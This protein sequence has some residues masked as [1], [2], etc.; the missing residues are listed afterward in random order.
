MGTGW[1]NEE[2]ADSKQPVGKYMYQQRKIPVLKGAKIVN[3]TGAKV[4]LYT[5]NGNTRTFE[6]NVTF[7]P[8]GPV[9]L[10]VA[11]EIVIRD[12]QVAIPSADLPG[13]TAESV[14]GESDNAGLEE[15]VNSG[16]IGRTDDVFQEASMSASQRVRDA[17]LEAARSS[18]PKHAYIQ[19]I[20]V[21]PLNLK[22]LPDPVPNT[23]YLLSESIFY[24]AIFTGRFDVGTP[25]SPI[26]SGNGTVIGWKNIREG[27]EF[28]PRQPAD[29]GKEVP[30]S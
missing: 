18:G 3:L 5:Y 29:S 2:P 24:A 21:L 30:S 16:D 8:D 1:S 25:Y 13:E 10:V 4:S 23:V 22:N 7:P 12:L 28:Y 26:A 19:S 9:P 17:R 14:P 27:V 6:H 15:H 11:D 20:C